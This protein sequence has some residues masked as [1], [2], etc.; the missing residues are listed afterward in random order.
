MIEYRENAHQAPSGEDGSRRRS[1]T[2]RRRVHSRESLRHAQPVH[3]S[4]IARSGRTI[5]CNVRTRRLRRPAAR[6]SLGSGEMTETFLVIVGLLA[7]GI[8]G[9]LIGAARAG[10]AAQAREGEMQAQIAAA[11]SRLTEVRTQLADREQRLADAEKQIR[12]EQQARVQAETRTEEVRKQI[13]QQRQLLEETEKRFKEAFDSLS[14]KALRANN[15]EFTRQAGER[16]KPLLDALK[17]YEEQIKEL[18]KQRRTAYGSLTEQLKQI[19]GTHQELARQTTS[20]STALRSPQVKGRWGELTLR[21]A[22]ELAGLSEH[23]DFDEQATRA[24]DGGAARPDLVVRLPG[25]RVIVVD[26][27]AP[28]SDYLAAVEATDEQ[29]RKAALAAHAKAIR[30][31]MRGLSDKSYES[32]FER[33]PEFVVMFV[34]GEAFFAAALEQDHELIEDGIRKRVILASPTTLIALLRTVGHN[35]QQQALLENARQISKTAAE[36]FERVCKFAEHFGKT[37]DSLRRA[38]EAYNQAVGSWERRILPTGRRI[39]EMGVRVKNEKSMALEQIEPAP[40]LL[41]EQSNDDASLEAA[42]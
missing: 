9:W 32:L 21:N 4:R 17:R 35:W 40:R 42:D 37:G 12:L 34:P 33:T 36:L 38:V 14:A 41:T 1:A 2:P 25:D 15:E 6:T 26:A 22:V 18:E 10:A 23:C 39:A 7:G 29:Q 5:P 3:T 30:Q 16:I 31:H 20:L 28:T 24:T 11:E 8:A 13:E 19:A 27:K